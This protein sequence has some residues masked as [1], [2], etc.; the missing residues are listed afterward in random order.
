VSIPLS[1]MVNRI[2]PKNTVLFFGAGSSIPSGAPSV[3]KIITHISNELSIDLNGYSLREVAS[4][5]EYKYGRL[6]LIKSLRKL[7]QIPTVTGSLLNLPLYNWKNIYTT[8]FD[9]LIEQSYSRKE[10]SLTVYSS[11]FDFVAQSVPESIKL[12]KLHG[13][14]EKDVCDGFN[15]RIVISESDYDYTIDYREALYDAFK[16]DL[17]G[18]NLVIIGY[19]LSDDGIKDIVN[20]A[21]DINSKAYSPFTINL[22]LYHRDED[23]ASLFERRGIR[24]AFGGVDDFFVEIA[25]SITPIARTYSFSLNPLDVAPS[26]NSITFDVDHEVRCI[27]KNVNA[28]YQGCAASYSDINAQLTFQR[29]ILDDFVVSVKS[30]LLCMTVLGP[31]GIGK[32]TFSR[33]ALLRLYQEGIYCWEHKKDH[34]LQYEMWRNVAK[35]LRLNN[36]QGVLFVDDAHLHLFELNNLIDLLVTDDNYFLKIILTSSR[37]QWYPRIKTPNIYKRGNNF[38]LNKLDEAEVENLLN[39]VETSPEIRNLVEQNFVGFSRLERKRRL[40]TKCESDTFVCLKNIFASEKF[41]DIVLREYAE[42]DQQYREVY[43]IVSAMED[44]GVQVHRQLIIR[45]LG[46]PAPDVQSCLENLKDIVYEYTVSE[47]EGIYGWRGRHPVITQII[48][49]Y[50]M[51]DDKEYFALIENV[52]DNIIPTY[53]I[54][55]RTIKQLCGFESGIG[56]FTDKNM[57]SKLFRKLISIAPG[58]RLPRH[59]LIRNLIDLN[60]FDKAETEIRLFENDFRI[61][62]PVSRYK[63]ILMLARA[64]NSIGILDEDRIVILEKAKDQAL[65]AIEKYPDNKFVLKTYCEVGYEYYKLTGNIEYFKDAMS[66]LR[67]AEERIS[68]PEI[69]SILIMF[70]RRIAGIEFSENSPSHEE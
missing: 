55:I 45:L 68:D 69:T 31:S 57:R 49:S 1:S 35:E 17:N 60:E 70:E 16:H 64:Q 62:G 36:K 61:D 26:L 7:F 10:V 29:T 23:R 3:Q 66:K 8:N 5:A 24:V 18:S 6:A 27:E 40:V 47:R 67:D 54:E 37:N 13:T 59:R 22:V 53:D 15:G 11:N 19:S 21:I 25:R 43:R 52:I 46:I 63:I 33:H 48:T 38:V 4:I 34:T 50:K 30:E 44:A 2:D 41:D 9:N 28:M 20:R 56:R 51:S 42:L 32:T 14:I 58:E 39:L 65:L 12:F